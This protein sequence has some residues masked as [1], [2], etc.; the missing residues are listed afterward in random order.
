[1]IWLKSLRIINSQ[2]HKDTYLEFC[3]GL[4]V[5]IG[6]SRSGKSSVLRNIRWLQSNE[7]LGTKHFRTGETFR[8]VVGT[9][10]NGAVIRRTRDLTK[11][12]N[13]YGLTWPGQ[14]EQI[15]SNFRKDPP[16]EIQKAIGV[17][18]VMIDKDKFIELN[19]AR[20]SAPPFLVQDS[21]PYR[22]KIIGRIVN[23]Q[24]IDS[25]ARAAANDLTKA[26]SK[27][28]D[29]EE[30]IEN[31][32]VKLEP[33]ADL[34]LQIE[35]YEKA[36][37][38]FSRLKGL[39]CKLEKLEE[40]KSNISI[41]ETALDSVNKTLDRLQN[42]TVAAKKLSEVNFLLNKAAILDEIATVIASNQSVLE[43]SNSLLNRLEGLDETEHIIKNGKAKARKL[44][45]LELLK[46]QFSA[47]N[48]NLNKQNTVLE[49]M[50]YI[51]QA[52][53]K[54][55]ILKNKIRSLND[56]LEIKQKTAE[57]KIALEKNNELLGR[58]RDIDLAQTKIKELYK[59]R[60]RG[61]ELS[62]IKNQ[63]LSN[64]TRMQSVH[65]TLSKFSDFDVA[66]VLRQIRELANRAVILEETN[67]RLN[68]AKIEL[69]ERITLLT[70]AQEK[71]HLMLDELTVLLK[72][73]GICPVCHSII[74]E[75]VLAEL[76]NQI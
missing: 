5:L 15:F 72:E 10:S 4:N 47:A 62:D 60:N 75:D 1:M 16:L 64:E 65:Q 2:S 13:E 58:A 30:K 6:L 12:T 57:L 69:E 25:A 43:A 44:E 18:K 59:L 27:K 21:S 50:A 31:L 35:I 46:D 9:Y 37:L 67:N 70:Q 56:L 26:N 24:V 19:F 22:A 45:A 49:K 32:K 51:S 54:I 11:G 53:T 8:E 36:Q 20:Q 28:K 42:I 48:Q 33:F 14:P 73:N 63:M 38:K 55:N 29:L 34:P 52:E 76:G 39:H 68:K 41:Q 7:P 66:S 71:T 40:I 17:A 74:T 23:L 61:K 3:P